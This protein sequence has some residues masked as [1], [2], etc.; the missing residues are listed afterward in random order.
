M[1]NFNVIASGSSGNSYFIET[2]N[3]YV[4][5]DV[6][7]SCKRIER[8][9]NENE[10]NKDIYLFITHEHIDHV[11][12]F[13]TF[14]KKYKPN[15]FLTEGTAIAMTSKGY[16]MDKSYIVDPDLTYEFD[17]FKVSPFA[18]NHDASQPVG[19]KFHFGEKAIIFATDLGV[20][21]DNVLEN[22]K[23]T[24]TV[25]LEFNYEDSLIKNGN[26]PEYLKKRI[27]SIK[28]H[29]SNK[30]ALN[31]VSKIANEGI[32]NL[33][34]AHISE[35][36]NTYELVEKY[37]TMIKEHYNIDTTCLKQNT[38]IKEINLF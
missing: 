37:S 28:G 10:K 17:S 32:K 18:I 22:L 12:G 14:N 2:D 25:V 30:D 4:F 23:Y 9:F 34:L 1:V 15:V 36:N 19:Y 20:V 35:N 31:A 24:E 16:E 7:V 26:Y 11:K 13:K 33:F 6:G 5:I 38:P 3:S 27:C 8:E 21:D 29:L